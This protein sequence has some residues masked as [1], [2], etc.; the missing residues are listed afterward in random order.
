MLVVAGAGPSPAAIVPTV[1]G[2]PD[3]DRGT[4]TLLFLGIGNERL[5]QTLV[6]AP[7]PPRRRNAPKGDLCAVQ[8][9]QQS[10]KLALADRTGAR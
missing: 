8:Q 9:H 2:M 5:S 3:A 6:V 10:A 1:A 4:P 7:H